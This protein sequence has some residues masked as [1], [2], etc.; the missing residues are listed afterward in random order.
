VCKLSRRYRIANAFLLAI[1]IVI[2]SAAATAA[3]K[4]SGP[5]QAQIDCQ[6]GAVNDYWANMKACEQNLS[7]LPDQLALCQSD[8]RA[9]LDRAKAACVASRV[10]GIRVPRNILENSPQLQ[11][12]PE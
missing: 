2:P 1:Y 9:D 11:I 3:Q 5:T 6:N 12:A 8:A 10:G 7:D 4:G